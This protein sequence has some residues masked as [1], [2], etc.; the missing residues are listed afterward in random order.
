MPGLGCNGNRAL[1][2]ARVSLARVQS[3]LRGV[4]PD[5]KGTESK[6][7][8]IA[9]LTTWVSRL[10]GGVCCA[11]QG[12][13]HAIAA[14]PDIKVSV[15]SVS[16]E[17]TN[18]DLP[19]W[20]GI[21]VT[22]CRPRGTRSFGYS[23]ELL[24]AM[25][26]GNPD[27]VHSHGMWTYPSLALLRWSRATRRPCIVSPHG[28]LEPWARRHHQWKKGPIWCLWERRNLDSAAVLHATSD[29]EARNLSELGLRAR[30]AVVP[31]GVDIPSDPRPA[32]NVGVER[33]ALF[34]SRIHPK[35]GLL[36]LIEA[37]RQVRPR[38]W[39]LLIAGPD[40][41]NHLSSVQEAVCQAGLTPTVTFVGPVYGQQKLDLLNSADLFIL[42]TFSENF[43]IVVAEALASAV[44]VITTKG[45][46]WKCLE[47]HSCGWWVEI[48]ALPLARALSEATQCSESE[49]RQMGLR[50]R[51]F[52]SREYSW[53]RIGGQMR[54]VYEWVLGGG[55]MPNCV[56][57]K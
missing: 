9:F 50:G 18:A 29:Q 40:E 2:S 48:G 24:T 34:L 35:K 12:Y 25:R 13:A 51:Q 27:L 16:D 17:Y 37:W 19:A 45:A 54:A 44:P 20:D 39:R 53:A 43:G 10:G 52:V 38:G 30:I 15:Y 57:E 23:S 8:N 5:A 46:P 31:I 6:D 26:S 7:M 47:A 41:S 22:I 14:C 32:C 3:L 21:P 33:R 11:A 56:L 1:L 55:A 4:P 28:M 49:L 42:P 36:N